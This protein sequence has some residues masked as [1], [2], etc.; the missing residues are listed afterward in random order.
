M[1]ECVLGE[2]HSPDTCSRAEVK[3][4]LDLIANRREEEIAAEDKTVDMMAQIHSILL[5]V[6]IG[7]L[8]V[9]VC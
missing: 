6:I 8:N 3:N 7:L 1:R 4:P 9:S 5:F 2:I